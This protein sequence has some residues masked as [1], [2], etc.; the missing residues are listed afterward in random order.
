MK[1]NDINGNAID[2]SI[3][4]RFN[5]P[6]PNAYGVEPARAEACEYGDLVGDTRRGGS[7]NFERYTVISHCN[8]T[9]T[10]CVGHITHER[11]SIRE[12]LK[13]V[14]M[15]AVLVSVEPVAI[16]ETDEAYPLNHEQQ[17]TLITKKSLAEK[18]TSLQQ[19]VPHS[20]FRVPQSEIPQSNI[21]HSAF[22]VPQSEIPHSKALIVRTL[23][24]DDGKLTREYGTDAANAVK[25]PPYFTLEAMH[26]I[27]ESGFTHLL[28][29]LPSID[30]IYDDGKLLNHR[31]FWN[32]EEG[33]RATNA[34][35][36]INNTITELIY[37]SNEIEDG[38]YLLNLQIA[39][40]DADCSPSRPILITT[41]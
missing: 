4:L 21:P 32:V 28:C 3:P 8:G 7:V 37:V 12:C 18:L 38:E 11:I 9:H 13:D 19:E 5:G 24:N 34:A 26:Y 33:S 2:I 15:N 10:E 29:D 22:R 1:S 35:T 39:P 36:R 40:F 23:P 20:A 16:S 17:D 27:V 41:S 14:L 30:R 6:Q 31:I 25:I